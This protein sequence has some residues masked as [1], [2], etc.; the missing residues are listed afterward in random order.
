VPCDPRQTSILAYDLENP[1]QRSGTAGKVDA[2]SP[3][4]EP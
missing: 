4:Q 2:K 1:R 3:Q